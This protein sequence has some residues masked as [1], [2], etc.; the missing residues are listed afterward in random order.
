MYWGLSSGGVYAGKDWMLVVEVLVLG[1]PNGKTGL[2]IYGGGGG[3]GGVLGELA[4][5][6][7]CRERGSNKVSTPWLLYAPNFSCPT[8]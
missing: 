4:G 3:T 1:K 2:L 8:N 5:G 6:G 7:G